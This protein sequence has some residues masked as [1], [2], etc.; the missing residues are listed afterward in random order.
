MP[1]R[2]QRM[3]RYVSP[4][5][6]GVAVVLLVVL[7]G[8]IVGYQVMTGDARVAAQAERM[9]TEITHCPVKIK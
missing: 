8:V 2:R 6:R 7:A 1:R 9:L 3:W 5:R 4:R